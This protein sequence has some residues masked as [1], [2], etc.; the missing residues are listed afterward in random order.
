IRT[1]NI[2][3]IN[4]PGTNE[5][6]VAN[7]FADDTTIFLNKVDDFAILQNILDKWCLAAGARFNIKKTQLLPI[8]SADYRER[9]IHERQ[10]NP[11]HQT[12]PDTMKIIPDGEL[13][14][15]LG[16]WVG[17]N[18]NQESLWTPVLENIDADLEQWEKS[19]PTTEGRKLIIQMVI[20]GRTQYLAR[21][22]GMPK[23]VEDGLRKRIRTFFWGDKRSP[24]KEAMIY[25][26]IEYGGQGVLDIQARNEAIQI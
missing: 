4:I 10:M 21:V 13:T 22:Q 23:R 20:G 5:K 25:M 12:I 1:S 24:I 15:I 14:R 6:L 18:G 8:G 16:A 3:G 7:L 26:P 2:Q 9:V 19:H 11:G 17:N